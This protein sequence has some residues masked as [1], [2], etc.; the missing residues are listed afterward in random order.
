MNLYKEV[1]SHL[2]GTEELLN[3]D[4]C[5]KISMLEGEI[6]EDIFLLI[7]IHY[8]E[9]IENNKVIEETNGKEFPYFS[10]TVTKDGKGLIFK[11]SQIPEK[12]QKIIV[13]YLNLI[14]C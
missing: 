7:L 6:A 3:A 8:L 9:N 10:K 1:L 12:L 4:Y 11:V 2:D 13:R 5:S 14:T